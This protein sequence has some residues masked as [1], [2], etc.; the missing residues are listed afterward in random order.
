MTAEQIAV[1]IQ[2]LA[3]RKP[4]PEATIQG[5][6]YSLLTQ[7]SVGL[8]A[9]D[10]EQKMMESPLGDGTRR[11]IDIE[12]GHVVIEVK[13]NLDAADRPKVEDQ[14]AGYV[15][16]RSGQFGRYVG[17]LTDGYEWRLYQLDRDKLRH[18]SAHVLN[19]KYPD[20]EAL[21]VWLESV[22]AT[23]DAL[24]PVP[25]EIERRLGAESPAHKVDFADL[26]NLYMANSDCPQVTLKRDLWAKLLRTAFGT[27]F[28]DDHA[29][30][31]T[32]TLLVVVRCAVSD[33]R[34]DR[35]VARAAR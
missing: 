1:I 4:R 20:S 13:K 28:H 18:V 27:N 25:V 16:Q 17:I 23:Q 26:H 31:L 14:L 29:L 10:V 30:F 15:Q 6:I 19:E 11:R 3:S 24:A 12:V 32:H 7:A 33:L 34:P 2:R 9:D 35:Q 21:L 22:M 5:D 8:G